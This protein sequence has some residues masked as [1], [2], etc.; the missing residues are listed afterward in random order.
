[1]NR[2]ERAEKVLAGLRA[3]IKER[4]T[5]LKHVNPYELLVAT[6]LSAQ[7]TDERIN[8]VSPALFLAFP[9]VQHMAAAA[10][11]E[12]FPFI[13]SV[14][15]PNNK[16]RHLAKMSREIVS[17][18]A[19]HVPET[20]AGLESLTGVGHKTAQVVAGVA[21]GVPTLAV[22]THVYRV[23]HRIG[24]VHN[25]KT[26]VQV[27]RQL[28]KLLPLQDWTDMH[29]VLILHGRY[30]CTARRP[31]CELCP[32]VRECQ[33][34]ERLRQLPVSRTGLDPRKGRYYCA[35]RNHY[36]EKGDLISDRSGTEQV[37]CP[38]CGSMNVFETRSGKTT[39]KVKD[40]RI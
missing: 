17:D 5:E 20:V 15:Y 23:A 19:G 34:Y 13:R 16:S 26:V 11:D 22:D 1:M 30:R 6:I 3:V 12:I 40:Y 14:S 4:T 2:K 35:T 25:A 7:C 9:T 28:K 21:F 18:H 37:S 27:E 39:K 33:Y 8:K 29:H 36:F 24:L 32:I 38:R 10:V 31:G